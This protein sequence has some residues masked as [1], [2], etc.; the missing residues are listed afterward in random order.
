MVDSDEALEAAS[1]LEN[2]MNEQDDEVVVVETRTTTKDV[3]RFDEDAWKACLQAFQHQ[4]HSLRI[5]ASNIAAMA[6]FHPWKNLPELLMNLVYQG[7][8]GR[9]L[10]RRDAELLGLTLASEDEV[11]LEL[12]TKAG[13]EA[14]RALKS[15]LQVKQGVRKVD[16]VENASKL[17]AKVVQEAKK[18]GKLK[19]E[20][21]RVLQEG[22]RSA[23]DTGYGTAHEDGALDMYEQ[24]CGWQVLE[25]NAEIRE[26]PFVRREEAKTNEN[27][28]E[29]TMSISI[30]TVVPLSSATACWRFEDEVQPRNETTTSNPK[31]QKFEENRSEATSSAN[32]AAPATGDQNTSDI[33]EDSSKASNDL[34]DANCEETTKAAHENP[35]AQP[36][37]SI[38]G[39]VDGIREE[40]T[41]SSTRTPV[42]SSPSDDDGWRLRQIVV[43]CKHRMKRIHAV[44]PLYEQIQTT[45]YCLMY[46]AS[47]ADIVQVMRREEPRKST[48]SKPESPR[49]PGP[50]DSWI[51]PDDSTKGKE[52]PPQ[53][54]QPTPEREP[55][56]AEA[57]KQLKPIISVTR[58]SLDD[59]IMQHRK[60]WTETILP[61]LRQFVEAVYQIRS[62]DD[63]R[64][65]L[66]QS[67]SDSTGTME[68]AWQILFYECPYLQSCETA[69]RHRT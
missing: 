67:V 18:T 60:H 45:A 53:A 23:V 10:L 59:P 58:V 44:P 38:M 30:P 50:L 41:P 42:S 33:P 20:E 11:L 47:E 56:A 29:S 46:Q 54:D 64:Y 68:E 3:R 43:E 1:S 27:A 66:L 65:R 13:A 52:N 14:K 5:S 6:G 8:W 37:F 25:R 32:D 28:G 34:E 15:A 9:A 48:S 63:K 55:K 22:A 24:Q 61:R 16:S 36:F 40:L 17:K 39:S 69:H 31:R 35:T 12:A 4:Q 49:K 26:W 51:R 62:D 21:L 19:V 7:R 2:S 57:T